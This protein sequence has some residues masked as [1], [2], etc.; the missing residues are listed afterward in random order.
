MFSF[1]TGFNESVSKHP[2]TLNFWF[3]FMEV[4]GEIAKYAISTIGNRPKAVSNDKI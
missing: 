2:E 3:D 1:E 4:Q